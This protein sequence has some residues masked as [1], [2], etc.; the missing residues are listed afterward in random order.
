MTNRYSVGFELRDRAPDKIEVCTY[1]LAFMVWDCISQSPEC[2]W[3]DVFDLEEGKRLAEYNANWAPQ[4]N[5]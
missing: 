2:L 3:T 4:P 1:E 5:P